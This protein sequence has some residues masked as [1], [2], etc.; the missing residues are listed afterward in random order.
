MDGND[1]TKTVA[2][3]I[4]LVLHAV[5]ADALHSSISPSLIQ[6]CFPSLASCEDR[7]QK[8]NERCARGCKKPC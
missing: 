5:Q 6:P 7:A 1:T 2:V 4:M 8:S 3:L